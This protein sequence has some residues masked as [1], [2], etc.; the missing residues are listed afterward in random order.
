MPGPPAEVKKVFPKSASRKWTPGIFSIQ[1]LI[2]YKIG[3]KMATRVS[4]QVISLRAFWNYV[5]DKMAV[6]IFP[7]PGVFL[8]PDARAE[9]QLFGYRHN[10]V[11]QSRI[12]KDLTRRRKETV[13][14]NLPKGDT[15]NH[16][17]RVRLTDGRG[18]EFPTRVVA[19]KRHQEYG[20]VANKAG[21]TSQVLVPWTS[22]KVQKKGKNFLIDCWERQYRIGGDFFPGGISALGEELLAGPIRLRAETRQGALT[23]SD[24]KVSLEEQE[25]DHAVFSLAAPSR[26]VNLSGRVRLEYDGMVRFDWKLDPVR[27]VT[28]EHLVLEIP[29]KAARAEYLNYFPASWGN[30]ANAFAIT[31]DLDWGQ[32]T[33]IELVLRVG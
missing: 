2:I 15:A 22:L 14:F 8:P 21:V 20:W 28:L 18:Q 25:E 19:Q 10:Q 13:V 26:S 11:S 27:D 4:P 23:W 30:M 9:V 32:G 7:E 29:F 33:G 3:E 31:K 5:N 16:C 6:T 1:D 17:I 24:A 12:I